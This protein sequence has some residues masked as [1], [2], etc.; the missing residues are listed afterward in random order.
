MVRQAHPPTIKLVEMH[1]TARG[2]GGKGRGGKEI[3]LIA[4]IFEGKRM[5][6]DYHTSFAREAT[7]LQKKKNCLLL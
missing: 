2:R 3:E 6:M 1:V 7:K 4:I 5:G